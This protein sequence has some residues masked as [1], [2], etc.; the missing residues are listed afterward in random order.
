MGRVV[1]G[2]VNLAVAFAAETQ[3]VIILCDDLPPGAGKVQREGRHVA[4]KIIHIENQIRRQIGLLA[5]H[6]PTGSERRE[7]EFMARGV[8]GF[9]SWQ[10]K[11]PH[12]IGC[13]KWSQ[14]STARGIDM[15]RNIKTGAGLEVVECGGESGDGFVIAGEGDAERG[16]DAD[17]IF[18]ATIHR[19]LG[20]EDEAVGG[21]RDLAEFHIPVARE[22]FPANL[23][24][25]ADEIGFVG[26][27]ACGLLPGPPAPF[28][29]ETAEHGGFAGAGG[30]AADGVRG[31]GGIP[32]VGEHVDAA[33][34]ER[35]GLWILV[36]VDHVFVDALVHEFV[37][38]GLFPSLAKGRE[39]LARVAVE[40]QLVVD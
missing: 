17:G 7:A 37:H 19:F 33:F 25:A 39:I 1:A 40:H 26:G 36:L 23:H 38:L 15:D 22:F 8:D 29:R 6:H 28:H 34:L 13:A 21:H 18:V 16:H 32:E 5:P 24:G 11:I 9:D 3:E 27:L 30:R 10:S 35:G 31:G 12:K 20:R 2:L 4:A 14:E